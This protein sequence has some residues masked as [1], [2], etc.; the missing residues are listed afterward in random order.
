MFMSQTNQTNQ[1]NPTH[2]NK[3]NG[4]SLGVAAAAA[5]TSTAGNKTPDNVTT[6]NEPKKRES[7]RKVFVVTGTVTE[8]DSIVQAEKFLNSTD[9]PQE[10]TVL[11]GT[12]GRKSTR[13]SLR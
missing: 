2:H 4:P 10:Y 11:Q 3:P 8:F 12:R 5:A 1:T 6:D 9:A 7:K 13:V